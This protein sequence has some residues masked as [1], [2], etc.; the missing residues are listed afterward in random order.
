MFDDLP[1]F[2]KDEDQ[3]R[4]IWSNPTTREKLLQDLAEAGYDK[5]KLDSMKELIDAKDSDVYDVLA[6][7]A[8]TTE[9]CTRSE[10]VERAKPR[11]K[12]ALSNYK[13]HEFVDFI[14]NKYI[15][16]GVQ[17]LSVKNMRGLIELK[18]HSI[19]DATNELGSTAVIRETFFG[20]QKHLYD[21]ELG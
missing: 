21:R 6:Y 17:Q 5:E 2:F 1:Q 11:I 16:D 3:L 13:Q 20:F 4:D 9:T 19:N 14:L 8:Y 10:R 7:V 12:K 15:V 18:Y